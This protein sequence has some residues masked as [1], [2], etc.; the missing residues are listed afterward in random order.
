MQNTLQCLDCRHF[1]RP[2]AAGPL[3]PACDA[4]PAG[5]P[6]DILTARHDHRE[7]YPGDHGIRFE[8]TE[9]PPE[10]AK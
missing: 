2:P 8:P 7:P 5:I 6:E 10:P 1:R 4:F 3:A 9:E